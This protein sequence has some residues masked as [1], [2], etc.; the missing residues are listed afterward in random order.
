VEKA[1]RGYKGRETHVA[2]EKEDT[3][4]S[5]MIICLAREN[6]H[7]LCCGFVITTSCMLLLLLLSR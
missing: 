5:E 4:I 1:A 6:P 7:S 2:A 3:S